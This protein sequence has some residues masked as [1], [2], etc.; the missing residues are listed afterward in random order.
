MGIWKIVDPGQPWDGEEVEADSWRR[1]RYAA[2]E[3]IRLDYVN[4]LE[5]EVV[6][7]ESPDA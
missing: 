5:F 7:R 1:A 4:T 2:E 6:E 3:I